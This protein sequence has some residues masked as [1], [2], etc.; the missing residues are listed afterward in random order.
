MQSVL[1]YFGNEVINV[2]GHV[3]VRHIVDCGDEQI[4]VNSYHNQACISLKAEC[5]LK[6]EAVAQDGI[7]EMVSHRE[8]PILGTMWHP[9]R[10]VGFREH[11]IE[12]VRKLF[13]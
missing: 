2:S 13:G 4:E 12:R 10:E 3:A 7:I 5:G 1:D 6:V 11:D 9:E 8:Y